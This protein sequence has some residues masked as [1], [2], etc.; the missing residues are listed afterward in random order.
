MAEIPY[1]LW[2]LRFPKRVRAGLARV[3]ERREF[4]ANLSIA[5]ALIPGFAIA[6][7]H[8]LKFL[9]PGEGERTEEILLGKLGELPVGSSKAVRDVLGNDLIAVHMTEGHV[10]VFSSV[11]THLGCRVEWD[12]TRNNFYCPCHQGRFD[13]DGQVLEGPPPEPLASFPLRQDG[14]KLFITLPV[15]NA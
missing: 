1:M 5:A 10:R 6:S 4:L 11:C 12:P 14:D 7:R 8:V 2:P 9:A 13:T 3:T 15:R